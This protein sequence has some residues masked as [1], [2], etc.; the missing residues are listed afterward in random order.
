MNKAGLAGVVAKD[1]GISKAQAERVISSVLQAIRTNARKGINLSG[2]G[3]FSVA[4]RAARRCKNPRN[5]AEIRIKA[6]KAV[7]FKPGKAFKEMVR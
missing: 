5:G 1:L 6:C 3:N 7:K 2:F 4:K